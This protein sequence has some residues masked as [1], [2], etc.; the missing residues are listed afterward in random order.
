MCDIY[1]AILYVFTVTKWT[2]EKLV[3]AYSVLTGDVIGRD[4]NLLSEEGF[5]LLREPLKQFCSYLK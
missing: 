1:S 5:A 4:D 3:H 2:D